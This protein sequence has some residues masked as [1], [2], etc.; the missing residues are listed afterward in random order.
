MREGQIYQLK[1]VVQHYSW[2]GYDYIPHLLGR[3]NEDKIPHAELWLGAHPKSSSYIVTENGEDRL[4]RFIQTFPH[5]VLGQ[6][7]ISRFKENLPYLFK[8]LDARNMLSIQVHPT[9]K[10]AEEGF[11]RENDSGIPIDAP[12]RSYNDTNHKPEVHVALN[13]FWMLHAFRP[14]KDIEN[15]IKNIPEFRP[16]L[17]IFYADGVEGLYKHIMR[18]PQENVDSM[19][20]PLVKRLRG[21]NPQHRDDPDFWA[22]KAFD[23]FPQPEN[24]RDRGIF[25]IYLLNLVHLQPGESTFQDAGVLHAYLFGTTVELM[26]NS[27]NVLRGGL[28]EKYIDIDE[29]LKTVKYEGHKPEKS[30][31]EVISYAER[32]Y[33]T[34]AIDFELSK[35]TLFPG[36]AFQN[37]QS[38]SPEILLLLNGQISVSDHFD[39]HAF[40]RGDT[41]FSPA[42]TSYKITALANSTLFRAKV[43]F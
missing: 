24:R 19:L 3:K 6:K 35:L 7:V 14:A 12:H 34:P 40:D 23:D 39:S 32:V 22:L 41:F 27:D 31:G 17:S 28:T 1:G 11:A 16:L 26:A 21:E 25:S 18:L 15:I 38:K 2:G 30:I 43:P 36:E 4:D 9:K 37:A 8:V 20:N 5:N 33:K 10:Q 13:D 29:L 42:C